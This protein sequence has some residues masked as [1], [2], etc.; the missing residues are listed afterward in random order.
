MSASIRNSKDVVKRHKQ[1]CAMILK[2]EDVK[3]KMGVYYLKGQ[4]LITNSL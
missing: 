1:N 3:P 2:G 4:N